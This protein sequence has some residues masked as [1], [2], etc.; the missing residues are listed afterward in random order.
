LDAAKS[1]GVGIGLGGIHVVGAPG[2]LRSMASAGTDWV[3][4]K[5]GV[6]P[7]KIAAVKRG[8]QQ[9]AVASPMLSWLAGAP[10]SDEIQHTA[11]SYT[12][13]FYEPETRVGDYAKTLGE[14]APG[15][16]LGPMGGASRAVAVARNIG[17]NVA[18][19]ALTSETA[20]QL[21]KGT[22][23]EPYAR[24]LGAFAGP[25]G[26]WAAQRRFGKPPLSTTQYPVHETAVGRDPAKRSDEL[27]ESKSAGMYDPPT[28][29]PRPFEQDYPFR[30][31]QKGLPPMHPD[32]SSPTSNNDCLQPD[33]LS[34][35]ERWAERMKPSRQRKLTPSQR[36]SLALALRQLRYDRLAGTL[37]GSPSVSTLRAIRYTTSWWTAY[38]R[39]PLKTRFW[40]MRRAMRLIILR[41]VRGEFRSIV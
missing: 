31:G 7:E 28:K 17:A 12:G 25:A 21:T 34:A 41:V 29:P 26:W 6:S 23:A 1:L 32:D 11:E 9:S 10:T 35:E 14:F 36:Q 30:D 18:L 38:L 15:A 3:G 40:H 16:V 39:V 4:N 37:G 22:W 33:M 5:L 27:L 19:P 13:K 8:M 2:D 24:T 20:G